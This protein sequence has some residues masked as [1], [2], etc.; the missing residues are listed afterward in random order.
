[1]NSLTQFLGKY[2]RL[3]ALVGGALSAT[4]FAPLSLWPLALI[5]CALLIYLV[6]QARSRKQAFFA[7]W[8]FGVGHFTVSNIWIAVAFNFQAEMPVWLGYLSVL[9]LALFLGDFPGI[10]C[11]WRMGGWRFGAQKR[12]Q[13]DD[14]LCAG[15][16]GDVDC[17]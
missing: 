17:D 13:C 14:I 9:A 12:G 16:R 15:L 2:P 4:G 7:G 5:G 8:I 10:G 6:S 11:A 3:A 1:M